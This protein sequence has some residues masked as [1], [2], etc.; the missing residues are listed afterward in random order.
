M[1]TASVCQNILADEVLTG[2]LLPDQWPNNR[3]QKF[4]DIVIY[5][6]GIS[7]RD[8]MFPFESTN[9]SL[10]AVYHISQWLQDN[11]IS[12]ISDVDVLFQDRLAGGDKNKSSMV[13][14]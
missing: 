8:G 4:I 9:V 5:C 13:L 2:I 14:T 7:R 11:S 10:K 3:I 12:C 1:L 6:T